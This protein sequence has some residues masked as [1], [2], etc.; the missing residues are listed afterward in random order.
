M[1]EPVL[2]SALYNLLDERQSGFCPLFLV[3]CLLRNN[4]HLEIIPPALPISGSST[5][6]KLWL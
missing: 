6:W 3:K 5:S 4:L 1:T 2:S